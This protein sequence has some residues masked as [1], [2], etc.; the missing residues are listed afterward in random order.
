M[1]TVTVAVLTVLAVMMTAS[2]TMFLAVTELLMPL[3]IVMAVLVTKVLFILMP[4]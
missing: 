4:W 2:Q 1:K 3:A